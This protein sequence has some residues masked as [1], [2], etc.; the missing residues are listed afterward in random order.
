MQRIEI[1]LIQ[2]LEF[3]KLIVNVLSKTLNVLFASTFFAMFFLPLHAA[4]G[5]GESGIIFIAKNA[6]ICNKEGLYIKQNASQTL[7][8]KSSK[9]KIK[10]V[11]P[12]K[13]EIIEK[14]SPEDIIVADFPFDP[15]PLS[16]SYISKEHAMLVSQQ[17]LNEYQAACKVSRENVYP[18]IENSS[19]SLYLPQQRQ[20]LSVA[21]TQCGILTSF[22]PNSPPL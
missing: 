15:T 18:G 7:A 2:K 6:K 19:F 14:E 20:K 4:T 9:T 1:V 13:N 21:A 3:I 5:T 16:Y 12:V 8:K 17:R 10:T 22:I 11:E